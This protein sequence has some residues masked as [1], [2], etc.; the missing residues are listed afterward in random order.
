MRKSI[1]IKLVTI[2][3][4]IIIFCLVIIG[5]LL[6]SFLGGYAAADKKK[7]LLGYANKISEMTTLLIKNQ[8]SLGEMFYELNI[9]NISFSTGS[10]IFVVDNN[11]ALFTVSQNGG[12]IIKKQNITPE[13]CAETLSGKTTTSVGS[14]GGVFSGV[15][16]SVGVP[17]IVNG[18]AVGAVYVSLSFPELHKIRSDVLNMF[19]ASAL[20]GILLAFLLSYFLA[21]RL[22]RPLKDMSAAAK[23]IAGGNFEE[24]IK[25]QSA[26]EIGQLGAAFNDMAVSLENLENMRRGFVSDVSHELRTPMT[27]ISG[28]VE[29]ILD[30]TIPKDMQNQYL[31]IVLDEARRLGRLISDLLDVTRLEGGKIPLDIRFFDINELIRRRVASLE[32]NLAEKRLNVTAEFD[33]ERKMVKGDKDAIER[34]LTNI[35]DNAVKFS[36]HGGHIKI[37]VSDVAQKVHISIENDGGGIE[38]GEL[39]HIWERFYKTDKSRAQ[40]KQGTG[41]GLYIVQ[42]IIHA[43]GQKVWAESAVGAYTR[44]T[45][46]LE[47]EE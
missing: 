21:R 35:L 1:F 26:D 34:V 9:E 10:I 14:L 11:A 18:S 19:A 40:D 46:T 13:L 33:K 2:N 38:E 37:S 7:Q 24:R 28:F 41:L 44:F 23:N 47:K 5:T 15:Y 3:L 6:F 25:I 20:V 12:A 43:H 39:K 29:G 22:S 31:K 45:F 4:A 42:S 32:N 27:S 16:L 30:G 36:P 8:N 17:I